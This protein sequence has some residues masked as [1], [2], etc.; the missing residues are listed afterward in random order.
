MLTALRFSIYCGA[1]I[2]LF[3]QNGS[4]WTFFGKTKK[5]PGKTEKT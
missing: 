2:Y 5:A 4:H 3:A 1:I